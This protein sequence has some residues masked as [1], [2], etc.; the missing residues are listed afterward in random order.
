MLLHI[1]HLIHSPVETLENIG[2][3]PCQIEYRDEQF[4][5]VIRP[6]Q[7]EDGDA[8]HQAIMSS[9]ERL[10]PFMEWAHYPS[11]PQIQEKR[12][13]QS[14]KDYFDGKEYN[15]G[16]FDARTADFLMS[17]GWLR[18]NSRNKN[19]LEI[20]YWTITKY[21]GK[22]LATLITKILVIVGMEILKADRIQICCHYKNLASH[23]VIEKC[24][25]QYEGRLR[26]YAPMPTDDMI[27]NGYENE[28]HWDFYSLIP[29]DKENLEWYSTIR[30]KIYIL[31]L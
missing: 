12:L 8:V 25:F 10:K 21:S 17:T 6:F 29:E 5:V 20:G 1:D 14:R 31:P 13:V 11:S 24:Q 9:L 27:K 15:L 16:V 2:K 28:R 26:N 4:H 30:E 19:C 23:R 22:G 7:K 18:I 3:P